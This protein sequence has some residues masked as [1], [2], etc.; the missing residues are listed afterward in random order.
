MTAALAAPLMFAGSAHHALAADVAHELGVELGACTIDRFPDGEVSVRI[1]ASVRGRDVF[2]VQP[3]SP[4]VN[5]HLMELLAFADACRRADARRITALVPYFG[6]ARSDRRNGVRAPV[7]ARVVAD[8]M[9]AVGIGRVVTIDAHTPQVEGFFHIPIDDLSAAPPLCAALR[10]HLFDDTVI[11]SP[12]LGGARRAA[13]FADRL[14]RPAVVC[15]KRRSGGSRVAVTQV[16]GAVRNRRCIIVDDMITT[17][18]TVAECARAVREQGALERPTVAVSHGVFAPGAL[19]R[20]RAAG[21]GEV[22]ATDSIAEPPEGSAH[23]TRVT[24]APLLAATVRHLVES[25]WSPV[26]YVPHARE[27]GVGV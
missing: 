10:A 8:M 5:E 14:G 26:M 13:D 1:D 19:E 4:P 21:V 24:I 6:Y 22:V 25:E 18:A 27:T 9:Q 17:G 11:V 12:D 7:T 2:V 15:V 23:A 3:T 16:I 20:L